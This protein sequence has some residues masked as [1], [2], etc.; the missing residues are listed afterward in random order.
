M[1]VCWILDRQKTIQNDL[2]FGLI[3]LTYWLNSKLKNLSSLFKI[4]K[5]NPKCIKKELFLNDQLTKSK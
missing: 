5:I 1:K 2:H 3:F 4:Y